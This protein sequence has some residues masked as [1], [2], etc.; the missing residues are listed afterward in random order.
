LWVRIVAM[1]EKH[2]QAITLRMRMP[3][4][5]VGLIFKDGFALLPTST[6]MSNTYDANTTDYY[7]NTTAAVPYAMVTAKLRFGVYLNRNGYATFRQEGGLNTWKSVGP[8]STLIIENTGTTAD[9]ASQ[10]VS[11]NTSRDYVG[12]T[13]MNYY[14]LNGESTLFSRPSHTQYRPTL[15]V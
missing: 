4:T 14:L 3:L 1:P 7:E 6:I 13:N 12:Y 2:L 15:C 11:G 8:F 5:M 10:P 9:V